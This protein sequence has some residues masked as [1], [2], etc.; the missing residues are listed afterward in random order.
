M[1]GHITVTEG[2]IVENTHPTS[3]ITILGTLDP[4]SDSNSNDDDTA[5]DDTAVKLSLPKKTQEN[6]VQTFDMSTFTSATNPA[7]SFSTT[8]TET[9]E[10]GQKLIV[11]YVGVVEEKEVFAGYIANYDGED[12]V[13]VTTI[14]FV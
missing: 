2:A 9:V 6:I 7:V 10:N 3:T 4:D 12:W 1:S 11:K 8:Q 13:N 14:V 5:N